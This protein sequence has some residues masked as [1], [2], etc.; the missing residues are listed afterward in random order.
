MSTVRTYTVGFVLSVGFTLA[1]FGLAW[2]YI[3]DRSLFM[4]EKLVVVLIGLAVAQLYVQLVYFL[5]LG[6]ENKPRWNFITFA[7]AAFVV[8]ILVGG[9]IWIMYHLDRGHA[10]LSE[11]YQGGVISPQTQDD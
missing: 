1:A 5:H 7:F 3:G 6:Q 11:V 4:M 2:Q 8:I 9:T 10:D